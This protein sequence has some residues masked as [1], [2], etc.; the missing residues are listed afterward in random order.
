MSILSTSLIL[1]L[2]NSKINFSSRQNKKF[3]FLFSRYFLQHH[4]EAQDAVLH[5][6]PDRAL[7]GY[8]LPI[9]AGLLPA[10]RLGRE[11]GPV[12]FHPAVADHVLLAHLRDHSVDVTGAAAAG[13]IS[14]LHHGD[15]RSVGRHHHHRP[16]RPLPQAEHPQNGAVG[17]RGESVKQIP[18]NF[19][20]TNENSQ[21]WG[22]YFANFFNKQ[23]W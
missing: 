11:G 18:Y 8:F 22:P 5:C 12:H 20:S 2:L 21:K 1:F 4:A 9:G 17:E 16:Q 14:P 6:E 23:R 10:S 19:N 7:R 13:K 15:G 3:K